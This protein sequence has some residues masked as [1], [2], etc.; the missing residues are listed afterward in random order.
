MIKAIKSN[1]NYRKVILKKALPKQ[2]TKSRNCKYFP[3]KLSKLIITNWAKNEHKK[4]FED[5]KILRKAK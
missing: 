5:K 2:Y 1:W 4:C 3:I